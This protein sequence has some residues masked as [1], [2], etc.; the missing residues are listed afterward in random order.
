MLVQNLI[1]L[2]NAET[3]DLLDDTDNIPYINNAIDVLSFLLDSIS[4]PEMITTIN[5]KNGDDIPSNFMDFVPHNGYPLSV[6]NS[7]FIILTNDTEIYNVRY[8]A[9][10]PHISLV[11]DTLPFNDMYVSI[12]CFIAA[13]T[14][15]KKMYIPPDYCQEDKA[16]IE[17]VMGLIKSAKGGS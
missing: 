7:K 9:P 1:D 14:I 5:V 6:Q 11:S 16:F 12:L 8:Y 17:E 15:K 13:Y 10:K 3:N 4:S 2:I